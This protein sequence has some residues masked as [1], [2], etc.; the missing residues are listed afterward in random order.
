ML[1]SSHRLP[2]CATFSSMVIWPSRRSTRCATGKDGS[3]H[4]CTAVSVSCVVTSVPPSKLFESLNC[5]DVRLRLGISAGHYSHLRPVRLQALDTLKQETY[6]GW[7]ILRNFRAAGS[8]GERSPNPTAFSAERSSRR[9]SPRFPST[10]VKR[11]SHV[12]VPPEFPRP[13]RRRGRRG[14][15]GR[16]WQFR[17]EQQRRRRKLRR[18]HLLVPVRRAR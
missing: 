6:V 15:L 9:G 17:P 4:R 5:Q 1:L 3:C 14:G 11:G 7:K 8:W 16:L 13:H 2:S 10:E 12:P 18:G